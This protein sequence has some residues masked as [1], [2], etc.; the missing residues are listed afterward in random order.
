MLRRTIFTITVLLGLV[1]IARPASASNLFVNVVADCRGYSLIITADVEGDITL[2]GDANPS[3]N[4]GTVGHVVPGVGIEYRFAR[5]AGTYRPGVTIAFVNGKIASKG[6]DADPIVAVVPT[7][8][9]P[10]TAP[11]TTVAPTTTTAVE[12]TTTTSSPT[13]TGV[14]ATT[15]PPQTVVTV[16]PTTSTTVCLPLRRRDEPPY[17]GCEPEYAPTTTPPGGSSV[18]LPRT[19]AGAAGSI[20]WYASGLLALGVLLCLA[21]VFAPR[22]RPRQ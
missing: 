11:T 19:G 9:T 16:A 7:C 22:R 3:N 18:T 15:A 1:A 10:T 4:P 14:T 12:A 20:A 13:T 17:A 21:Q 5:T 2:W 8:P 6:S